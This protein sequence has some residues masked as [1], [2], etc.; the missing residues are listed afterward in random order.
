MRSE[1]G[2]ESEGAGDGLELLQGD[3][4]VYGCAEEHV[5]ADSGETI[6]VGNAHCES[7]RE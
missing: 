3:T 2:V 7:E 5:A 6:E 4:G 1:L